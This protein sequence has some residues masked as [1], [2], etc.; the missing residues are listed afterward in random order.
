MNEG[1]R[2]RE[3]GGDRELLEAPLADLLSAGR[4]V[5]DFEAPE[6]HPDPE[7]YTRARENLRALRATLAVPILMR[8]ELIG[9]LVL[10]ARRPGALYTPADVAFLHA[11]ASQA[12]IALQNA[13]SYEEVIAVNATLEQRVRD[14]TEQ[15]ERAYSE[16]KATEV[17]LVQSE[18]MASLGRLV[19]GVAHE[20]N[21]PVSFI[22]ASVVPLRRRLAAAQS[23]APAEIAKTLDEA[24]E[25][26]N[27][28]ERGAERTAGIV[29]DLRTFSRIGEADL[30]Q[31]DLN[32]N[33]ESTVHLVA[34]RFADRI[35]IHRGYGELPPF[36]CDVGRLNQVFMNLLVNACEAIPERGNV[37]VTTTCEG[38]RLV[39]SVRDDGVGMDREILG[40][41]FAPFFTTKDVGEGT[42]LG[43]VISHGV[44]AAHGGTIEV[45]SE[46]GRGTEFRILLPVRSAGEALGCAS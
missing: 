26:V 18:K 40:R 6:T 17:Q 13:A 36:E 4:I 31:C 16:L 20:I 38:G 43:L 33:I 28:I 30:K 46:V 25:L 8:G 45:D 11:L 9:A 42:G 32:E 35:Q 27:I 22:A 24:A 37:W 7:A 12:A 21:N 39:I 44:V 29:K 1:A 23:A 15:L 34:S 10:G 5:A 19:A 3:I 41:I 14:R 2:L